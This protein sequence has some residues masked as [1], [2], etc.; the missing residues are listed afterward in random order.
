MVAVAKA[1]IDSVEEGVIAKG[2]ADDLLV[3]VSVFIHW[4]AKDKQKIYEYN[5][6]ATKLA[7]KRAIAG[8]PSVTE[9][10]AR[11]NKVIH[12]FA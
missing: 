11:K 3:I 6:D 10:L 5:Y 1:V 2:D 4:E 12:P 7:I 8:E 9:A